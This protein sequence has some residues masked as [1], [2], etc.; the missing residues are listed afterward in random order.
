MRI[1]F[2]LK[3]DADC[4][5]W[6]VLCGAIHKTWPDILVSPYLMMACSD[7]RHYCSITDNVYRFSGMFMSKEDRAMIHGIDEKISV[8]T[9][10]TTVEFYKNLL[11][12]L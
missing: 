6:T 12:G 7:S 2:L 4:E 3:S 10:L 5:Q 1:I 8:E 9:L 11:T